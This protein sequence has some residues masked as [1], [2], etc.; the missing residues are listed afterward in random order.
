MVTY[1]SNPATTRTPTPDHNPGNPPAGFVDSCGGRRSRSCT[2][3]WGAALSRY[4]DRRR[5]IRIPVGGPVRWEYGQRSGYG[6]LLDLSPHGAAICLP[7]RRAAPLGAEL[8]LDVELG[9]GLTWRLA[10]AARVVRRA[11][12]DDGRCVLGLEF[13]PD[14]HQ[15]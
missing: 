8:T 14:Q 10:K 12:Q 2:M 5:S 13:A 4:R 3:A 7:I 9:D 11:L 1:D 6:E 15:H